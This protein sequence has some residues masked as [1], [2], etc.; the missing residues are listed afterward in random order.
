MCALLCMHVYMYMY[1]AHR[2]NRFQQSSYL[3][4]CTHNIPALFPP[5]SF[6]PPRTL[7]HPL[8]PPLS[9]PDQNAKQGTRGKAAAAAQQSLALPDSLHQR[10]PRA[11]DSAHS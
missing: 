7:S 4:A 1:D 3:R 6:L 9:H 2:T 5:T 8:S 10:P 11:H